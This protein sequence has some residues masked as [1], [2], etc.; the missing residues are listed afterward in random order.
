MTKKTSQLPDIIMVAVTLI[1]II[2]VVYLPNI[3]LGRNLATQA[4]AAPSDA[5]CS[6]LTWM[7]EN[8]PDPFGDSSFYYKP[9][10]TQYEPY[11]SQK[12]YTD[13]AYGVMAWWDYGYWISRIAH[14]IPNANPS[15]EVEATTKVA[16]FFTAQDENTANAIMNEMGSRYVIVDNA[17]A[18]YKFYA[19]VIWAGKDNI[20]Q[21][22][23]MAIRLFKLNGE[24]LDNY[25]LIHNAGGEVKIFEYK[26]RN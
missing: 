8:T 15:Q 7:K 20:D 6:S 25:Q 17:T 14:R 1:A 4:N 16:Q 5:W 23:S 10:S 24:G 3:G 11:S 13:S 18:T 26:G 2:G 21:S 19:M 12:A 9:Y 22:K